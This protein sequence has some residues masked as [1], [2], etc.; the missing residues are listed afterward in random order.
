MAGYMLY[1][2]EASYY[3]AKIRAALAWKRLPF[4]EVQASRAIYANEILPRV[5]W[6]VLP[7]LV[8][9]DNE[10]VQ[11][12]S[13]MCDLIEARHPE[14]PLLPRDAAARVLSYL[15]EFLGD[16]W[17]KLPA[18]HY[19][20]NYNYDF[21]VAEFGRNNDPQ[22]ARDEQLRV[23]AK[24]AR[25]FHGWLPPLGVLPESYATV[26]QDY[27]A[28]L[29]L[30]DNHFAVH[31]YLLGSAPTLGDFAFFGPLYA[32]LYRDPA[33]GAVMSARA[34]RVV[35]WIARLRAGAPDAQPLAEPLSIPVSLWRI[36][37]QLCR[38]FV[39]MLVG[40][41]AGVQR[42]LAQHP[43]ACELPRHCG[44]QNVVLGRDTALEVTVPR[45]LFTYDQWM[46][47]RLQDAWAAVP[48]EQGHARRTVFA[49]VGAA[50]LLDIA[51][52]LRVERRHFRLMRAA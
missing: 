32:H 18:M 35:A 5:G 33:S 29:Q 19:R 52:P 4:E 50:A 46:L 3:A 12:T 9:P 25:Q 38:D 1:G 43:S 15:L 8:T 21:A 42:F 14:P 44:T 6:P 26:E 24:I 28:F 10:T 22:H 31:P 51:V 27:L 20:W 30:L 45:A 39:P 47:Q 40:E 7:V 17:L 23:G 34:P 36:V 11:D 37:K 13:D 16:E 2:V 48:A 41:M 49:N